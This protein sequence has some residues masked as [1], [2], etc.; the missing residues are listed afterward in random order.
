[1]A[2]SPLLFLLPPTKTSYRAGAIFKFEMCQSAPRH[3]VYVWFGICSRENPCDQRNE[4]SGFII[5]RKYLV[6]QL[7][8]I[9]FTTALILRGFNLE[10]T[11]CGVRVLDRYE[12]KLNSLKS[13]IS[14][15]KTQ[16][17]CERYLRKNKLI[18]RYINFGKENE[19]MQTRRQLFR[20]ES[21]DRIPS[22]AAQ[23]FVVFLSFSKQLS[24]P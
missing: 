11:M 19:I 24:P 17:N 23:C 8:N 2:S 20:L 12:P 4:L 5:P 21:L 18:T 10:F 15:T 7:S 22:I 3:P 16:K 6:E 9:A 13:C 14:A 1:M